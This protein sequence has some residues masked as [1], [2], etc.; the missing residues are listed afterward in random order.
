MSYNI[1]KHADQTKRQIL[2]EVY[3]GKEGFCVN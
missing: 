2:M 1:I 3:F